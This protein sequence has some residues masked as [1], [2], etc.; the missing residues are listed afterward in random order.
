MSRTA[1]PRI[2][3]APRRVKRT[4][5]ASPDTIGQIS[6]R[7][8][9]LKRPR[10]VQRDA[11]GADS[12]AH[13][14]TRIAP[15]SVESPL[16][17]IRRRAVSRLLAFPA[18]AR[19]PQWATRVSDAGGNPY[20]RGRA[21]ANWSDAVAGTTRPARLRDNVRHA[22]AARTEF[23]SARQ[24]SRESAIC[25]RRRVRTCCFRC[26][27]I[28]GRLNDAYVLWQDGQITPIDVP[29]CQSFA[30]AL[31]D[32][33]VIWTGLCVRTA[34]R[35]ITSSRGRAAATGTAIMFEAALG[36]ALLVRKLPRSLLS[37]AYRGG[38]ADTRS[39]RVLS[40]GN[41]PGR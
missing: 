17:R 28:L 23:W 18:T 32:F 9:R 36:S 26:P 8:T 38:S 27:Q 4:P 22:Q 37:N 34:A 5:R 10:L 21:I 16:G 33:V 25:W 15:T 30:S 29:A 39:R 11:Y 35:Y 1:R 12:T 2:R 24:V 40:S 3:H 31:N 13:P 20:R 6:L 41:I 7:L 14:H 19:V